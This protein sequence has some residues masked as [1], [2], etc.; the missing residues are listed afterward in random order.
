MWARCRKSGVVTTAV[1]TIEGQMAY[2]PNQLVYNGGVF[3]LFYVGQMADYAFQRR[4]L[5]R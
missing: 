2:V 4:V 1:Q 3:E 5:R